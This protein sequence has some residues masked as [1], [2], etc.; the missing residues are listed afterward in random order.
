MSYWAKWFPDVTTTKGIKSTRKGAVIGSLLFAAS[1]AL[2]AG[3]VF[4]LGSFP[5]SMTNDPKDKYYSI[6]VIVLEAMFAL[7][8]AWRFHIGKGWLIGPLLLA[9]FLIEIG[10][11]IVGGT[12]KGAW[13]IAYAY[14]LVALIN[15]VRG[16]WATR[17]GMVD[18]AEVF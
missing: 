3:F 12:L 1:L 17:K 2:G 9:L 4:F 8:A 16:A 13:F 5:G 14:L 6:A 11:K 10:G 15:G 18:L 7:F